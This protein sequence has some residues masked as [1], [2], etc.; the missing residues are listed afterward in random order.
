MEKVVENLKQLWSN[1]P[2]FQVCVIIA[3]IGLIILLAIS[4]K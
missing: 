3:V 4:P 2:A 1:S